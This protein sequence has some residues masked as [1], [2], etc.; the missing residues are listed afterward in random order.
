MILLLTLLTPSASAASYYFLDSGTRAIGRGGAFVCGADDISAMYYNPAALV[1]I[2]RPIFNL[3]GWGVGQYV[4][5]DRLDEAGDDGE[6]GTDDD[7]SFE[8]VENVGSPQLEPQG[9]FATHLGGIAPILKDTHLALGLYV[10]TS[11]NM[12][13]DPDGAQ[14]YSLIDSLVW[15][16]YAG[17][18]VAQ[19]ITPWLSIGA[20]LEYTFLR[21]D[22]RLKV[23]APLSGD[24]EDPADDVELNLE[25]WDPAKFSWN[26]G[27]LVQPTKWLDVG[28]SV[29]PAIHYVAP[30]TL[31]VGFNPD[32]FVGGQ[33]ANE[34][35]SGETG[36]TFT[37]DD[38]NLYVTTPWIVRVGVQVKP[39]PKLRVEA[40][41][42]WTHW[43]ES[44][45]LRIE[46]CTEDD[47]SDGGV[48]LAHD[49]DS[50]LLTED[51][52]LVD[53][54]SILTG[55]V[56]SYSARLG[57][58]YDVTDW[59]RLAAGVH[60]E[61]SSVPTARQGVAVVDGNKWGVA[62]GATVR[63]GHHLAL[64]VSFAEQFLANRAITD[65]EL[66][67]IQLEVDLSDFS[68]TSVGEG[69]IVGNGQFTSRLTFVAIGATVYLGQPKDGGTPAPKAPKSPKEPKAPEEPAA[70]A[71]PSA[72][73]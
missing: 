4:R 51:I 12:A 42:T 71:E 62:A 68:N 44:E 18:S 47:C 22:Q 40:D 16:V 65:S 38:V 58:D 20:G 30:G 61:T 67:Q 19:R 34:D 66:R 64:D 23:S 63:V 41:G 57:A 14:R 37:D 25:T 45:E 29:Q 7:L 31:D 46:L 39:V 49:P 11:P 28:A 70:P 54:I 43:S 36:P 48:T 52:E 5:F 17:P 2:D 72:A 55:F 56:D 69:T 53:D 13:Y 50:V 24:S 73:G 59:L 1:N 6:F 10:P 9:G 15:Q 60:Y 27:L 35:T 3:N 26:A 21:V 32:S 8:P 33:L